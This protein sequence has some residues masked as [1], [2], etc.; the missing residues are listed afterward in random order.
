[1]GDV[2][3]YYY[4]GE[5]SAFVVR[6]VGFE[7]VD[8]FLTDERKNKILARE[9]V[10]VEKAALDAKAKGERLSKSAAARLTELEDFSGSF[11]MADKRAVLLGERDSEVEANREG[12][13]REH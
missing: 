7:R 1:M 6:P 8:D 9:D 12:D 3:G 10:R 4:Q 11:T 13:Y 5:F 2:I